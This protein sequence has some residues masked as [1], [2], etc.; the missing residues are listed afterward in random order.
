MPS[1]YEIK[2]DLK[3]SWVICPAEW[4]QQRGWE[5]CITST[6]IIWQLLLCLFLWPVFWWW[7][8]SIISLIS[9]ELFIAQELKVL[10]KLAQ[11]IDREAVSSTTN[12]S[13]LRD[14]AWLLYGRLEP[15]QTVR[16]GIATRD[17]EWSG[18]FVFLPPWP[19]S[20]YC[21]SASNL[22]HREVHNPQV[23]DSRLSSLDTVL[24]FWMYGY[25]WI[26]P[27]PLALSWFRMS[28]MAGV[29]LGWAPRQCSLCC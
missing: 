24:S 21:E 26:Y 10:F 16:A 15:H 4:S 19:P 1:L 22:N 28:L 13:C 12:C 29:Y 23:Y 9:G 20:K 14:N 2:A 17:M 25:I 27:L 5:L 11:I 6:E 8:I 18:G 3:K 7:F